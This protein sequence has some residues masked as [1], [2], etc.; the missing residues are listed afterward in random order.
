M[1]TMPTGVTQKVSSPR[2]DMSMGAMQKVS[3][4][5]AGEGQG[6][7]YVNLFIA[8]TVEGR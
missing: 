6:E 4:P 2:V 7:G 1:D 3:S 5:L 8:L